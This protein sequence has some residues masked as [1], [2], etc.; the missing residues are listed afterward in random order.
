MPWTCD[1]DDEDDRGTAV[2]E[3]ERRDMVVLLAPAPGE[4]A[5]PA[6]IA[7]GGELSI[8]M[9]QFPAFAGNSPR[10]VGFFFGGAGVAG[11]CLTRRKR[12]FAEEETG[13]WERQTETV[14]D[15]QRAS[16]KTLKR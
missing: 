14:S 1:L 3:L 11:K 16:S 6:T 4:I 9:C 12:D 15:P 13:G 2:R 7:R 8:S 10:R 5:R